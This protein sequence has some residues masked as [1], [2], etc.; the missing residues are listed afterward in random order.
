MRRVQLSASLRIDHQREHRFI[1]EVAA[2]AGIA[3][4]MTS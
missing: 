1:V 4:R 3:S 2:E